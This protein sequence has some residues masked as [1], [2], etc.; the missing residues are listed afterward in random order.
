MDL[1]KAISFLVRIILTNLVFYNVVLY[2]FYELGTQKMVD[3]LLV[4]MNFK[5]NG[6]SLI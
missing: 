4:E 3:V 2:F 1:E 6:F 5:F